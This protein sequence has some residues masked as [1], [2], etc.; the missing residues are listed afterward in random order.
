MTL[1]VQIKP[2]A[3]IMP[4]LPNWIPA[5]STQPS[6]ALIEQSS[7]LGHF[8]SLS[9]LSPGVPTKFFKDPKLMTPGDRDNVIAD[10]YLSHTIPATDPHFISEIFFLNCYAHSI[11]LGPT[12]QN[13]TRLE[14][15]MNE[16][17]R[18][19]DHI[20]AID[21]WR[22]TPHA[23]L[24]S[25]A[26]ERTKIQ[27]EE[28]AALEATMEALM[29]DRVSQEKSLDFLGFVANWL[30][31]LVDER[32]LHP[33]KTLTLPLK[34]QVP[35]EW[36]CLPQFL[37]E[38]ITDHLLYIMRY[39]PLEDFAYGSIPDVIGDRPRPELIIVALTFIG[40]SGSGYIQNPHLKAKLAEML[41]WGTLK[42]PR[43]AYG[44]FG[45]VLNSNSFALEWT[46]PSVMSFYIGRT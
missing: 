44:L 20:N 35:I 24:F 37:F 15:D 5:Q 43:F 2:I 3:A 26:L 28:T 42:H 39:P 38:I 27:M 13:H 41:Y 30:L 34:E 46:F 4:D 32:H 16:L 33:A 9:P 19:I 36:R 17:Q 45:E 7:F 6:G 1:L 22:A 10:E 18:Q 40:P 21:N 11:G 23:A 25:A 12:M 8:F 29:Y 31:R 14:G